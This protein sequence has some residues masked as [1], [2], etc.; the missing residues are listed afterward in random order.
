MA[1]ILV[2]MNGSFID[3]VDNG[4]G[5]FAE[6]E[7]PNTVTTI[8]NAG[9]TVV[10]TTAIDAAGLAAA[11][12]GQDAFVIPEMEV[13]T[14]LP[15][16]AT[17]TVLQNFVSAGGSLIIH[18]GS[19]NQSTL[20][21]AVFGFSLTDQGAFGATYAKTA[22]ATGAFAGAA[23]SLS[24]NNGTESLSLSALP[25]GSRSF[26]D[27]GS[28][29]VLAELPYGSGSIL[30]AGWDW[31][32]AAPA[33]S[34]DN[35]WLTAYG[36]ALTETITQEHVVNF[37]STSFG[38][39]SSYSEDGLTFTSPTH[40]HFD[41][42]M[43][44]DGKAELGGH[45]GGTEIIEIT[46]TGGGSFSLI[47]MDT[48]NFY[49][50]SPTPVEWIA[51]RLVSG[52][53][54]E[55]G[56]MIITPGSDVTFTGDF[57]N[58]DKVVW[59]SA[60]TSAGDLL[61]DNIRYT[62]GGV[63]AT[64][65]DPEVTGPVT[66]IVDEDDAPYSVD[67][68][69]G[70]SDDDGDTLVV[71]GLT[72]DSGD[73]SGITV[74]GTS[75]D[76]DPDAYDHLAVGDSE[77]ISYSYVIED[78]NGGSVAQTATVTITGVNDTPTVTAA[79]TS[80]ANE[81]DA[82]Y[83]VNLL[84]GADDD[85]DGA[86]LGVSGLALDSGDDAG[87]T[88][89]GNSL[90][91]DPNAYNH[92]A[93]GESEV[94]TY[95][96]S[97]TDE[98]GGSVAQTATITING[99]ND[100]PTANDDVLGGGGG[101]NVLLVGTEMNGNT[102]TY[103]AS[104][105][106]TGTIIAGSALE[107]TDL[108]TYDSIWVSWQTIVTDTGSLAANL[109]SFVAGGGNLLVEGYGSNVLGFLPSGSD[110]SWA[111]AGHGEDVV[112]NATSPLFDGLTSADM[113][114]WGNSYHD[115]FTL[116]DYDQFQVV[117]ENSVGVDLVLIQ[118]YG[119]GQIVV[120]SL[121]P[122]YHLL[123]G[124]WHGP[125]A[126]DGPQLEF[127]VNALTL[128]SS[129]TD[130]DTAIVIDGADLLAND[131]DP[132]SS[133]VLTISGVSALSSLGGAVTLNI[134]GTIGYDPTAALNYLAEG[135]VVEDSFTYTISDGNGGTDTA[136]VSFTV[137]G[138]NDA[139]SAP[140]DIDPTGDTLTDDATI[141]EHLAVGSEIGIEADSTDPEGDPVTYYFRDGA[142]AVV[143][144]LGKF[145][146]DATT[147]VVTLAAAVNFELETGYAL[148]IYASDGTLESSSTFN[149]EVT[150][151]V[152]HLFTPNNDGTA[153]APID[154]NA[155]PPGAYDLDGAQYDALSGDD[156]VY[157]PHL[158]TSALPGHVWDYSRTFNASAGNDVVQGGDGN[159]IISGGEGNDRLF[160]GDGDDR[161][162][163]SAGNDILGGGDGADKMTGS[164]GKDI[165][166]LTDSE[167][168]TTKLGEHD[169][170]TDFQQGTDR[171]DISALYDNG[172]VYG[173][174]KNGA[175]NG[176]LSNANK[177]GYYTSGGKTWVE[178]DVTGDGVADWV[179]E[180]N[181]AYKL[182]GSDIIAGGS[183]IENLAQWSSAT[184]GLPYARHHQD[185]YFI[186]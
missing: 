146:I 182:K 33:G 5:S 23:A 175:L 144:T 46:R 70:A 37:D 20:L 43:D 128:S 173:G 32:D 63:T 83:S 106:L 29:T 93:V 168:G 103:L 137:V 117:A 27:N 119:F 122:S 36:A 45:N 112:I 41:L 72:L 131:T 161:L 54:V 94:I 116:S 28:N 49:Y 148:T 186:V 82:P 140:V 90:D 52:V 25:T 2:F 73:A 160:G 21:N 39:P 177:V 80:T 152:E 111:G 172:V 147:G 15:N 17:I 8:Q 121:D 87:V 53:F 65:A 149:V 139:P 7:G 69:A 156:Y 35:G 183:F 167:I 104:Q 48:S 154:F 141:S 12:V 127:A 64:N 159:D 71:S 60:Y 142:N 78:G 61:V 179:L 50:G 113:S 145:T 79:I 16:A 40:L 136:T 109:A 143:Q 24:W 184:G 74:N 108:S 98:H 56:R 114:T 133:D 162:V 105:G 75:L 1:N 18:G 102:Q 10:Q 163:G 51:Y 47:D 66:S 110:F 58:I 86:V 14:W 4:G 31:F 181:G 76:V 91:I 101:N 6:A 99:V 155:L 3:L 158:A 77:V 123:Y 42:D 118:Q 95:S 129:L 150:N 89:N 134:D 26:Y 38:N 100:G 180:M 120:T 164:S 124:N 62:T 153:A 55:T 185:D 34:L 174:L 88:V 92:L 59:N 151:V 171:I 44:S 84:A 176:A 19:G 107:A 30:Y 9:H 166:I 138:I 135:E 157:L 22:F 125:S 81:D 85:D 165:F 11:L 13:G 132:D 68:L 67:L 126:E 170:I 115:G 178:G 130:E 96:Y 97:V 169:V 57:H